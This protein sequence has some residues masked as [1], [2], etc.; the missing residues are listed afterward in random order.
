MGS[1]SKEKFMEGQMLRNEGLHTMKLCKSFSM[2]PDCG[3]AEF[4]IETSLDIVSVLDSFPVDFHFTFI[5]T[6]FEH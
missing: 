4:L 3:M 1:K 6:Q 5:L 2:C